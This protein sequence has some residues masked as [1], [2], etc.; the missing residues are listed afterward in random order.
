MQH[1]RT[2][3]LDTFRG[4]RRRYNT[5]LTRVALDGVHGRFRRQTLNIIHRKIFSKKKTALKGQRAQKLQH[6]KIS[7]KQ[8]KSTLRCS[9][10]TSL[11]NFTSHSPDF[12]S[13]WKRLG[14]LQL[15]IR[16]TQLTSQ[17][18]R[19]HTPARTSWSH[20]KTRKRTSYYLQ[21]ESAERTRACYRCHPLSQ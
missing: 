1:E 18:K 6:V 16:S 15:G 14:N 10:L 11:G 21:E 19:S 8:P 13:L 5:L 9:A 12:Q 20:L 3:R 4:T 7:E 2:K 17:K